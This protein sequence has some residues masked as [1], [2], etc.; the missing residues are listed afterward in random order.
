MLENTDSSRKLGISIHLCKG[1]VY[2]KSFNKLNYLTID[3]F[4]KCQLILET[5]LIF[6]FLQML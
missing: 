2:D 6:E 4:L 1:W 5:S 3:Y